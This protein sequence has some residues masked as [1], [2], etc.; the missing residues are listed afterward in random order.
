MLRT[1][2]AWL[3]IAAMLAAGACNSARDAAAEEGDEDYVEGPT[4][5]HGAR[6][7]PP[8]APPVFAR[9]APALSFLVVGDQGW[10]SAP[11]RRVV[12]AMAR[13]AAEAP[14]DFVLMLGD[15]FYRKGVASTDDEQW[16]RLF[17]DRYSAPSLQVPFYAVLGN[18]DRNGDEHAE[19]DY[20]RKSTRWR[21]P[22]EQ[23]VLH[24]DL[25]S[26][27]RADFFLLDTDPIA[28]GRLGSREQ[29]Y[30][31]DE[32]LRASNA[33]WKIV[34]GHHT[35][36]S[37]GAHG[38]T[39]RLVDVLE[40]V[41]TANQ[42]DL[43]VC[44]HDHDQQILREHGCTYLVSG[45]GSGPRDTTWGPSTVVASADAGFAWLGITSEELWIELV[46]A[47]HGPFSTYRIAKTAAKR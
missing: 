13:K 21:M 4:V 16:K 43:Y 26:G 15:N 19:V 8:F 12:D 24:R 30:R 45:A 46:G 1:R 38:D 47:D 10:D 11:A 17:E 3:A 32:D 9:G 7:L 20:S 39:R 28:H 33:R 40:P 2:D 29:V 14:I 42:V 23:Y 35:V 31:L 6:E 27:A 18:H 36:R 22:G 44:G 34:V 5:V 37:N 25:D 41:L